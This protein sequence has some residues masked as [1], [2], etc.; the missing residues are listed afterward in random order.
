MQKVCAKSSSLLLPELLGCTPGTVRA[1]VAARH[2]GRRRPTVRPIVRLVPIVV[3]AIRGEIMPGR[4]QKK[5]RVVVSLYIIFRSSVEKQCPPP[6]KKAFVMLSRTNTR[7]ENNSPLDKDEVAVQIGGQA[8]PERQIHDRLRRRVIGDVTRIVVRGDVGALG[9]VR[10]QGGA[11]HQI[12]DERQPVSVEAILARHLPRRYRASREDEVTA[13]HGREGHVDGHVLT[14]TVRRLDARC[15]VPPQGVLGNVV[16]PIEHDA[17]PSEGAAVIQ[18]VGT[19][20]REGIGIG[21]GPPHRL[22]VCSEVPRS[23]TREIT[24]SVREGGGGGGG[25]GGPAAGPDPAGR[26]GEEE[27]EREW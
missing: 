1:D 6:L 12:L 20:L 27:E 25:G 9:E 17:A 10:I 3:A 21:L 16:I 26:G 24:V 14:P 19:G 8:H 23:R 11:V 4:N 5:S 7:T 15:H 2:G 13:V 22:L 18:A